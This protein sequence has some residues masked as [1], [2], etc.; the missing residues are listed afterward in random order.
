MPDTTRRRLLGNLGFVAGAVAT[1]SSMGATSQAAVPKVAPGGGALK[2]LVHGLGGDG[3]TYPGW[4]NSREGDA[5]VITTINLVDGSV[6]QTPLPMAG[7]H[8]A[9]SMG[10]G[11]ILCL[12]QHRNKCLVLDPAHKVVNQVAAQSKYVFGGHGL[13]MENRGVIALAMRAERQT[14]LKDHGVFRVYDLKTLKLLDQVDSGGLQPH[15][16]HAI[17]NTDELAVTHYGDIRVPRP[18]LENNVI[19]PKLT[20]L[21]AR[22]LKPKRH[23]VQPDFNAMV[24][25][26]R[27]DKHGW[28][29][30]V[31][32]QQVVWANPDDL[33]DNEDPFTIAAHQLEKALGRKRTFPLPHQG[34]SNKE[35]PLPLPFIR[36]N[37]QNGERQIINTGDRNH[38]RSQSVA[39]SDFTDKAIGLYYYS[40]VMIVHTPGAEPEI[41]TGDE[42]GLD[43]IRGITEIPDTPFIAVMGNH[44][45]VTVVN[46]NTREIVATYPTLNYRD[47]HLYYDRV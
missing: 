34:I 18:P 24:T 42:L 14:R 23:Y 16:I 44:R 28:A 20:I 21:D 13:V 5:A 46:L 17:P 3:R 31:L 22:T 11:R 30:F 32:S 26:M 27:V 15:E 47:T 38:L 40:N 10:D 45:G 19:E 29:Y 8:A 2:G 35:F 7:G 4:E 6:R 43:D 9:M 41:I 1:A 25:H 39:Y 12:A 37:T 36:V 33:R